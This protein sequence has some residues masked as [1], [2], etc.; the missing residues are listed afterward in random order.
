MDRT[1]SARHRMLLLVLAFVGF[2]SLG[3]PD[4]MIGVVWP[5]VRDT[6]HLRQGA[7]AIV[8]VVSGFGYLISSFLSGQLIQAIGIG[9]LLAVST[10]MVGA[11]MLGFGYAPLW[12]GFVLCALVHG[13]GSG[14]IDSGLNGYAAHH[15][16]ARHMIWLHACYCFGALIGPVLMSN[17]LGRGHHYSVG[18]SIVGITMLML[19]AMFLITHKLWGETASSGPPIRVPIRGSGVLR[20][21]I[22]WLQMAIYFLY[23]GLE[24]TFSQ[25]TYTVLTESRGVSPETAGLAVG[26]YWGAIGVGRVISG[27][28]ADR[29]GIDRLIRYCLMTATFG[30]VLFAIRL[31]IAATLSGLTLIGLGLAPVYPCL[32]SRTPKRLGIELSAHAIGFQVGAAMLGAAAIPGM[33]GVLAGRT[34]LETIGVGVVVLFT[35]LTLLHESLIRMPEPAQ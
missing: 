35:I 13:L 30:A 14:A 9:L 21:P 17:V 1:H 29:F 16:S 31:P 7:I 4:A 12:L 5:S 20:Q 2:I 3:L 6:F 26:S 32:M 18:Y 11:A 8:L 10:A 22:V 33:L 23:T 24:V 19:A 28:V 27:T 15:M 34:G 25:W